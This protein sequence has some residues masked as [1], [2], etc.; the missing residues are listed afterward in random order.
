VDFRTA[1]QIIQRRYEISIADAGAMAKD[2]TDDSER[3]GFGKI[4][5]EQRLTEVLEAL[6]DLGK[7]EV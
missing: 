2:L 3:L 7:K 1:R 4:R 5:T 6:E